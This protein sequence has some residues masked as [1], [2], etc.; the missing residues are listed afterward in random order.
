MVDVAR[1]ERVQHDPSNR[2]PGGRG[3]PD[4]PVPAAGPGPAPSFGRKITPQ[5]NVL[6]LRFVPERVALAV[7]INDPGS[8]FDLERVEL[9]TELAPQNLLPYGRLLLDLLE[10]DPTFS[11]RADEAEES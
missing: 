3:R 2:R 5:P 9:D 8:P 11:V 6:R 10:G 1:R 7:N 4:F